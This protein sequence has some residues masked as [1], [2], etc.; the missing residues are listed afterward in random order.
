[1]DKLIEQLRFRLRRAPAIE[2]MAGCVVSNGEGKLLPPRPPNA[3]I[4][5]DELAS[6]EHQL[7]FALPTMVRRLATEVADGGYGPAWGINRLK[8]PEGMPF[9]PWYDVE[10]SVESW[11][12]LYHDKAECPQLE[13]Y[14][15]RFIRYCEVGCNISI[16]VDCTTDVARL[17]MDDPNLGDD[18]TKFLVP[19]EQTLDV[20][21]QEWLD[22]KPWPRRR[23]R[24]TE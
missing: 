23:Y 3:A 4:S 17:F 19:M 5:P 6:V 21:L 8:H 16:C 10:M 15:E 22:R 12:R 2:S 20:W 13:G 11:H 18:P 24:I 9:G 14:P 7:G 1:M